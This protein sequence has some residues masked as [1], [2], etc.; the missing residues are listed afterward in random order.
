VNGDIFVDFSTRAWYGKFQKI[1]SG[2]LNHKIVSIG[3]GM[4]EITPW[5]AGR[6]LRRSIHPPSHHFSNLN[7][8]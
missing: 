2:N 1:R 5:A 7:I 3:T 4:N 8:K 6:R